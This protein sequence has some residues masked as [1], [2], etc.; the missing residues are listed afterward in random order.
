MIAGLVCWDLVAEGMSDARP[1]ARVAKE[2]LGVD[3]AQVLQQRQ[4]VRA[5]KEVVQPRVQAYE[6]SKLPWN[7]RGE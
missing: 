3:G 4:V 1:A 5:L 6:P 7:P 2:L